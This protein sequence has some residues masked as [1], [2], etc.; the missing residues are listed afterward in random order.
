[1][2]RCRRKN[3]LADCFLILLQSIRKHGLIKYRVMEGFTSQIEN[4]TAYGTDF[5]G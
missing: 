4:D 2:K 1:M 5:P 3:N